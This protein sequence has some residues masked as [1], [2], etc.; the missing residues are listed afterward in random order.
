MHDEKVS[1]HLP[2]YAGLFARVC[3]QIYKVCGW[4]HVYMHING[5][6]LVSLYVSMDV[7]V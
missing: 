1:V 6:M 4:V 5:Y 2:V 7:K 3:L